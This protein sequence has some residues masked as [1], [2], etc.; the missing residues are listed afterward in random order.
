MNLELKLLEHQSQ[1]IQDTTSRNLALVGGYGAGK[2]RALATKLITLSLLNPGYEGIALSPTYGMSNKVLIPEIEAQL[3]QYGIKYH[4]SK[5]QMTFDI[6]TEP[7]VSTRLHVLAAETY[8]RAAGINAAFF[9]VDECDLIDADLAAAAWQM[10]SSRLRK[11]KVFQGCAVSTPEGFNFMWKFFVDDVLS[12][13]ALRDS[14]RIIRASTYDN[15]FLPIEYIKEL[16]AQYPE[17]LIKA[18]LHGEFVN[19]AGK[20]VYWK[21]NKDL[22]VTTH[23]IVQFPQH[24]IHIGQDFNKGINAGVVSVIKNNQAYAI[25]ELYGANDTDALAREIKKRYPW[26]AQN[27]AI[28][29]YPDASGF[30]GI[31][32]L[33]R[34]FPEYGP[35]G[36]PNFRYSA[37]NPRI[38]KRVAAVNEKF[39]PV[40][41]GPD[42]F[43]N[44]TRCPELYK[45]LIQ[46]TYKNNAPDKDS[47]IDH[48]LDGFGYFI[49][50]VW[51]LTGNVVASIA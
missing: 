42:A 48:A 41:K 24:V 27:N 16:E 1:F 3:N 47:G 23:T 37:A 34:C 31:Q 46:Q 33:K 9:G 51:P 39:Q 11:G 29:F 30:E 45:G 22:N 12:N 49:Y 26:H 18:Y 8:K 50:K 14:R 6:F 43:V 2:T 4:L 36:Q 19:L 7:K 32:H 35:D 40:G 15:P 13:S 5:S 38:E 10:L 20:P 25:D 21:F 28:R 17:H 44:P